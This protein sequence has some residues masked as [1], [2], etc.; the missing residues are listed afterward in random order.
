MHGLNKRKLSRKPSRAI[1]AIRKSS[2]DKLCA[3]IATAGK[4][5]CSRGELFGSIGC[6]SWYVRVN[7]VFCYFFPLLFDIQESNTGRVTPFYGMMRLNLSYDGLTN[8]QD[9]IA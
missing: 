8:K 7:I 3:F 1:N 5:A 4:C 9:H 2:R 6:M